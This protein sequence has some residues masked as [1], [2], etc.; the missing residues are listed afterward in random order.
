MIVSCRGEGRSVEGK[1]TH[2]PDGNSAILGCGGERVIVSAFCSGKCKG[3]HFE[4]GP[5]LSRRGA[6]A[7]SSGVG[8]KLAGN[9]RYAGPTHSHDLEQVAS[10]D[11]KKIPITVAVA[12]R[13]LEPSLHKKVE[14]C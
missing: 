13:R 8:V 11:G 5:R 12:S 2:V 4:C 3:A 7:R 14:N 10:T 6:P 9:F 1:V